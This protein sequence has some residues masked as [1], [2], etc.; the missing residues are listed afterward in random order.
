MHRYGGT[1]E[2]ERA[3]ESAL[4]WFKRHQSA[5]GSWQVSSYPAS[6]N[7]DAKCEAGPIW[8][9]PD[10][11]RL[12]TASALLCF[13]GAGYDHVTP[14][15]Y[16]KVLRS[17]IGYLLQQ[18][19]A[20]GAIAE[21]SWP[22]AVCTNA[23]CEA[24]ALTG[25]PTLKEPAQRAIGRLLVLQDPRH[26]LGWE[27]ALS[28]GRSAGTLASS[29]CLLALWSGL[30]AGLDVH[31]GLETAKLQLAECWRQANRG[32]EIE[33]TRTG[34]I[35]S[36]RFPE[37]WDGRA[38]DQVPG[39][40]ALEAV[41][42]G[43]HG[44]DPMFESLVDATMAR[45]LPASFPCPLYRLWFASEAMFQHGGALWTAWNRTVRELLVDSQRQT[46]LCFEGSWDG[47]NTEAGAP[48]A[49]RLLSTA[50]ACNILEVYYRYHRL[51][52][53]QDQPPE[54]QDVIV[55]IHAHQAPRDRTSE[56]DDSADTLYWAAGVRTDA[57]SGRAVVHFTCAGTISSF[58]VL[59]DA[60]DG[61]G[62][63]AESD[64][65]VRCLQPFSIEPKMPLEAT[66]GDRLLLPVSI[67][68]LAGENL[69]LITVSAQGTTG[70]AVGHA[71]PAAQRSDGRGVAFVPVTFTG[72]GPGTL[73]FS[74]SG[75]AASDRV[76]RTLQVHAAGFPMSISASGRIAHDTDASCTFTLPVALS[77]DDLEVQLLAYPG[78]AASLMQ[79]LARL[80]QEPC[81]CFEQTSSTC[82]PLVMA[83]QY[84]L[85]HS[86]V[87][88]QLV[89][90]GAELLEHGYTRLISFECPGGGFEWFGRDPGH[91]ALTAYGLLEFTDMARV[92]PVSTDLLARTRSWLLSKRDGRGAFT[93]LVPGLHSWS[94]DQE[95]SDAYVVWALLES[96]GDARADLVMKLQVEIGR[97]QDIGTSSG[98]AYAV[99]L[100]AHVLH[101][102]GRD[103]QALVVLR[104]LV[105]SADG[106][107][108]GA[109]T[110]ITS[111]SGESLEIETTALATM[112]WR[113]QR[114]PGP[115]DLGIHFLSQHCAGGSYGSTQSTVLALRAIIAYDQ[116][117]EGDRTAGTFTVALDGK[118]CGPG[119][120]IQPTASSVLSPGR[121]LGGDAVARSAYP[122][123]PP[124]PRLDH[125]LVAGG[126]LPDPPASIGPCVLA[127]S[128]HPAELYAHRCGRSPRVHALGQQ[129]QLQAGVI[130]GRHYWPAG[131]RRDA[132]GSAARSG[133]NRPDLRFR[134]AWRRADP[135]LGRPRG[136]RTAA[137]EHRLVGGDP[138]LLHWCREPGLLLLRR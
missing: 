100:A 52:E 73:T 84:F 76:S 70:I 25:D 132:S 130:A 2:S 80:Q 105:Q 112:A 115:A 95:C 89:S 123:H 87:D 131:R 14:N 39:T 60:F 88:P 8:A 114:M 19:R 94:T 137:A 138:G 16:K 54:P 12:V 29:A 58:Q 81:G 40:G 61:R 122:G 71:E 42:L 47:A 7:Q 13:L 86:G 26:G 79:A 111:S 59:A 11:D 5:D 72:H 28:D 135:V 53:R 67:A 120:T 48:A 64:A 1:R 32:F 109:T 51:E 23:L 78:P 31:A 102:A 128:D 117:H 44:Q 133:E 124:A 82:Y 136:R 69:G 57:V 121:W 3:V 116:I 104:R 41:F 4:R 96:A 22:Q 97:V 55:R 93:L 17:G 108:Q 65:M 38:A 85:D 30:A 106:S 134:T 68:D 56:R 98:N 50:L 90:R 110:S 127:S 21:G 107:V 35:H 83:Q 119:L 129:C 45:E 125:A 62:A 10:G 126:V 49:G 33:L 113:D 46:P 27:Y 24:F 92:R 118:P 37:R 36:A 34:M 75:T 20:D 63:L 101:L 99:A 103:Q 15:R 77:P 18:Q 6:C 66:V 9:T 74:A 43:H 91:V